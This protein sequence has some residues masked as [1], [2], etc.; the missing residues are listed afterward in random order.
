MQGF[1]RKNHVGEGA[2]HQRV[3]SRRTVC[4]A[5]KGGITQY[6]L[7]CIK[8]WRNHGGGMA[9]LGAGVAGITGQVHGISGRGG[10]V[11]ITERVQSIL[12]G[13]GERNHRGRG[14]ASRIQSQ[15]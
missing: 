8:R 14:M 6:R 1:K 13:R 5:S 3:A 7:Q 11:G 9:P 10:V 15:E 4:R 2:G 12:G